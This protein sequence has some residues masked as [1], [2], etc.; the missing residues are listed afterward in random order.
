[1]ILPDS[2]RPSRE[3]KK[4]LREVDAAIK[5]RDIERRQRW[6]EALEFRWWESGVV[7]MLFVS[8]LGFVITI[9]KLI[10]AENRILFWFVFSWFFLFTLT[11]VASVEIIVRKITALRNLCEWQ[12]QRL[13]RLETGHTPPQEKPDRPPSSG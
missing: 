4:L 10:P 3:P 8:G 9:F 13:E 12:E 5:M 6:H 2:Y 1:M 11:L 7:V